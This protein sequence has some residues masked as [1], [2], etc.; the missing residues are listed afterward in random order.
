MNLLFS[1]TFSYRECG[2]AQQNKCFLAVTHPAAETWMLGFRR[3]RESL[4][5]RSAQSRGRYQSMHTRKPSN[6]TTGAESINTCTQ[7]NLLQSGPRAGQN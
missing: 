4:G 1:N 2:S 3:E 6:G 7:S 5:G